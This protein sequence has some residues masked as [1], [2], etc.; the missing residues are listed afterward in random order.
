MNSRPAA[1]YDEGKQEALTG[2]CDRANPYERLSDN[3]WE[4]IR[5]FRTANNWGEMTKRGLLK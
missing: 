5:G 4:W 2:G 1:P 3:W